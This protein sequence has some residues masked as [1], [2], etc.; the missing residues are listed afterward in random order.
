MREKLSFEL[1]NNLSEIERLGQ[2]VTEFGELYNLSSKIIF[3][4]NLALEEVVTNIISYGYEDKNEHQ[5]NVCIFLEGNELTV[6]VQDDGR[7]FNPLEAPEPDT[8]KPLQDR[9]IGGLGIH[10]VRNL[11]DG[12][13]YSREEGKNLLVMKKKA[14]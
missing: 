10:L 11:M 9:Q 12:L 14:M 4:V 1:K 8:R 13:E 2:T 3:A 6:E 7:P 5:I